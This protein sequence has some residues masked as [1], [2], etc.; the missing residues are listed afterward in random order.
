MTSTE[1]FDRFIE[2]IEVSIEE[3]A[4]KY[5]EVP[6]EFV[7]RLN[8][9]VKEIVPETRQNVSNIGKEINI[10]NE[11]LKGLVTKIEDIE[12][13]FYGRSDGKLKYCCI[14]NSHTYD[15]KWDGN[16]YE[17]FAFHIH[18]VIQLVKKHF[19]SFIIDSNVILENTY[20]TTQ[21][22]SIK[23]INKSFQKNEV[24]G[25]KIRNETN[26]NGAWLLLRNKKN[27]FIHVSNT[28]N[29]FKRNF[30]GK[31]V[32]KR[33]IWIGSDNSLHYFIDGIYGKSGSYG[34]GVEVEAGGQWKKASDCFIKKDGSYYDSENLSRKKPPKEAD[35]HNLIPIITQMNKQPKKKD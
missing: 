5:S 29:T 25:F 12:G 2:L 34:I 18:R 13:T 8:T 4:Y 1:I 33:I 19:S 20:Q 9:L 35:I 15:I 27:K 3:H 30:T 22:N 32:T 6:E 24:F 28:Y 17:K 7:S 21:E 14:N 23:D 16:I 10:R 31:I 26:L 11:F